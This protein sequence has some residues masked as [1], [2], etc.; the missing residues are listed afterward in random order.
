MI[1]GPRWVG[2]E[3]PVVSL[4]SLSPHSASASRPRCPESVDMKIVLHANF[5]F[6][7]NNT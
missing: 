1:P 6:V 2:S 5:S 7:F 4:V 3:C